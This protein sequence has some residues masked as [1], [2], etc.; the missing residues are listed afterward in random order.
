MSRTVIIFVTHSGGLYHFN[1][2][3]CQIYAI[4]LKPMLCT[5]VS[6]SD[7]IIQVPITYLDGYPPKKFPPKKFP[8]I[9]FQ[10]MT[11]W[12]K[13]FPPKKFLETFLGGNF[14]G[15]IHLDLLAITVHIQGEQFYNTLDFN[16]KCQDVHIL[17]AGL[18]CLL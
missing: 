2:F 16:F 11:T 7:R 10:K 15:R 3:E 5:R 18:Y 13:K 17:G 8:A 1:R 6:F 12:D 4:H 14:L 9:K